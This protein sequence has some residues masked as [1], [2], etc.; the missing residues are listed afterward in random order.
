MASLRIS[1]DLRFAD[2][3]GRVVLLNLATAGYFVLDPVAS[4]MW[5]L[6]AGT[7]R[8]RP[9]NE[10]VQALNVESR[11]RMLT[12]LQQR[13]AVDPQRLERDFDGFLRTCTTAGHLVET[14][15]DP[16]TATGQATPAG[17]NRVFKPST[18]LPARAWWSLFHVSR[19]LH[20]IGFS[21]AYRTC[22]SLSPLPRDALSIP[23]LLRRSLAAFALAENFFFLKRAPQD[24]LPRSLALFRFLRS[25]GLPVEHV[26]GVQLFPFAAHAWVECQDRVLHDDASN[27]RRF[28]TIA[29]IAA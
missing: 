2:V 24:C 21:S 13:F 14:A 8:V 11:Q 28:V 5:R 1:S 27:P 17:A 10:A 7:G 25:Q 12:E 9:G 22:A 23:P 3:D 29:R 19:L 20:R 16:A 26:I 6:L 15:D 18:L 4:A